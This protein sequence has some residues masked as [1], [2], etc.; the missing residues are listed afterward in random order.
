MSHP[1]R[2][3]PKGERGTV[4]IIAMSVLVMMTLVGVMVMQMVAVD[5]DAVG[6]ERGGEE[7]L[8]IAEAGIQWGLQEVDLKYDIDPS[9][10][11]YT[12]LTVPNLTAV[13][14]EAV[15]GPPAIV[16]WGQLHPASRSIAYG[17][18]AFRVVVQPAPAP[19]TKT[20]LVRSLGVTMEAGRFGAQRLLE[21]AVTPQ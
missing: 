18:G 8:Y 5:V 15:W 3:I 19:D 13:P 11:D 9:T 6:A 10:P 12:P 21:V 4:L 20:L 16:G 1:Y 17:G 2:N 7:A 14:S